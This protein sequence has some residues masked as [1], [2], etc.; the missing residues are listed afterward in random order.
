M[1]MLSHLSLPSG[2]GLSLSSSSPACLDSHVKFTANVSHVKE[3]STEF[4]FVWII[5]DQGSFPKRRKSSDYD[6]IYETF[7][8]ERV[9][10]GNFTMVVD[11]FTIGESGNNE[12]RVATGNLTFYLGGNSF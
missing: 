3:N 12:S 9:T 8:G 1:T 2:Y 10:S 7:N 5:V 4:I 11:V 6:E